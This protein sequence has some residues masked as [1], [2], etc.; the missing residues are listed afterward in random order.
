MINIS[1]GK[2]LLGIMFECK[3]F[4]MLVMVKCIFL[5]EESSVKVLE[6]EVVVFLRL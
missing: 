5:L 2:D 3:C 4:G 1:L 6:E